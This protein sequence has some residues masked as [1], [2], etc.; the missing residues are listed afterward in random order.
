MYFM[1]HN[2]RLPQFAFPVFYS[3]V[4]LLMLLYL[5]NEYNTVQRGE[6][7]PLY[8]NLMEYPAYVRRGFEQAD[9]IKNPEGGGEWVRFLSPPLRIEDSPLPDLPKRRYLSPWANKAEE[10]TILI[11][12]EMDSRAMAF[13]DSDVAVFP[14]IFLGYIGE[15]W[16]IYLNGK[17]LRSEMHLDDTGQIKSRRTWRDVY[18][19]LDSSLLVQGTNFLALRIL[20]DPAHGATG[21]YYRAPYYLDDYSVIQRQHRNLFIILLSG[22]FGFTGF[23]HLALFLSV[24]KKQEINNLYYCIFSFLLCVYSVARNGEGIINHLVPNSDIS[25]RLEYFALFMMVPFYGLLLESLVWKKIS[26]IS[27]A[28][29]AYS[30]LL[31]IIQIFFCAE[32]ADEILL[33]WNVAVP[34]YISFIFFYDIVYSFFWNLRRIKTQKDGVMPVMIVNILIGALLIYICGIIQIL[35]VLF[36]HNGFSLLTYSIFVLHIAMAFTL[37]QRFSDIYKRLEQSNTMLETAVHERTVELEKQSEIAVQ[38]S[39]AKSEFLAAMS[40][41]IRTPLNAVIGLSEIEL[42]NELPE[43][44]KNN[45]QQIHQSGLSLLGI[46]ND[47]LD[48]SKIEA[49][50]FEFVPVEYATALL[51]GDTV[52]LNRVRIGQKPIT[53][54]L[55]IFDDFPSALMGD[56]LRVK[57]VLNNILSNAIKYTM[58]GTV[59]LAVS[60]EGIPQERGSALQEAEPRV[61][62]RFSVWDT[63]IGIH[64]EDMG[65]LFT[66]YSQLNT[67]AN[68]KI[69]GTGLGLEITK[70]L[71]EMMGG[72][73][74]VES[75]YGK[76]SVFTVEII[77]GLAD[78]TPIGEETAE[79]LRKFSFDYYR[80]EDD[81]S[82]SWMPYGRVLV[83][84]DMPVNLQ[85]ARGLLEPYGLKIDTA[86]SG[87]EAIEKLIAEGPRRREGGGY[88]LIFMDHMMPEMDGIE[89]VRIIREW[90]LSENK[91]QGTKNKKQGTV[92]GRQTPIVALTANALVGNME[93][94]L[95]KGFNG[96]ISK[97]IDIVQLD[98]ALN[99]WV[100]DPEILRQAERAENHQ[101]GEGQ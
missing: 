81:I 42:R 65:K 53:F 40:H 58:E 39:K 23:Y 82:R 37:S 90:E 14:G 48:I 33:I 89:A 15:N 50:G 64:R 83:V 6:S 7:G 101:R 24:R 76:G 98:G 8:R 73:I 88:D 59:T 25:L 70:K 12:V 2:K 4:M 36:F 62:I 43:S 75:E 10:F 66:S 31:G 57:Q 93:M 87:Q 71:V 77:Q 96:F 79:S 35:D 46:I 34:L 56:E 47:I 22:I 84:D 68:R 80:K 32:F 20:G 41:E 51:I 5:W 86:A 30:L 28:F 16:E 100:R 17:L 3:V 69:E 55:E 99:R 54:I 21:L 78:L 1:M 95:S 11:P 29:L 74:T 61:K 19:P 60:W 97:P 9:I 72:S 94:F 45:I 63:G 26:K 91:E 13:L 92:G 67:K 27:I 85:V 49:G 38:A 52:N 44:R 18:F